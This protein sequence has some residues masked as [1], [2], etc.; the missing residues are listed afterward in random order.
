M[1]AP[2]ASRTNETSSAEFFQQ[3]TLG[4][5]NIDL[6]LAANGAPP[7]GNCPSRRIKFN[8]PGTLVFVR[9]DGTS[10]PL[11]GRVAGEIEDID[12]VQ[13]T[14]VGSTAGI[15]FTAYW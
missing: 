5:A 15:T 10:V 3:F 6:T 1:P 8:T 12:A 11:T 14:V 2:F 13:V 9:R 7:A 4:A